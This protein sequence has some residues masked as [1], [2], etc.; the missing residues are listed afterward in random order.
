ML[1]RSKPK[2]ALCVNRVRAGKLPSS[3][4]IYKYCAAEIF[5]LLVFDCLSNVKIPTRLCALAIVI[6]V[7]YILYEWTLAP[8]LELF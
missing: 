2:G 3:F 6:L 8:P 4:R 5:R 1:K 7:H